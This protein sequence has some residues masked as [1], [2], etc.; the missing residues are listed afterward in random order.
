M[1]PDRSRLREQVQAR[2]AMMV[3]LRKYKTC[4]LVGRVFDM[5]HA[6]VI[7]HEKNHEGNMLSWDGYEEKYRIAESMCDQTIRYKTLEAKLTSIRSEIR[8]LQRVEEAMMDRVRIIN[9]NRKDHE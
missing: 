3:A 1:K 4:A 9:E 7:H 8:R 6:T 2:A 5:D